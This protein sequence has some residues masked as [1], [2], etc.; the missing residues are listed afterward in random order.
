MDA[1]LALRL[2]YFAS[3]PIVWLVGL[4][5][6]CALAYG[7]AGA[8]LRDL[9]APTDLVALLKASSIVTLACTALLG[10]APRLI[11]WA[12]IFG[13]AGDLSLAQEQ[14]LAGLIA[15]ALGHICYIRVFLR[16]GVGVGAALKQPIR[17]IGALALIAAAV[18]CALWLI[19]PSSPLL[20]PLS[21]YTS[22]L[23]LTTLSSFTL[24][25]ARW[26]SIAGAILFFISDGFVAAALFHAPQGANAAFWMNFTGWMIYWAGQAGLCLG[27]LNL[28]RGA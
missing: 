12:L 2:R 17:V 3:H 1:P 22:I 14:F 11:A 9:G 18:L 15:F 6:G 25:R 21:A 10:R 20:A 27:M 24:P 7:L 19:P 23:T 4:S 28:R 13:G 26:P 16:E 5:F 8:R